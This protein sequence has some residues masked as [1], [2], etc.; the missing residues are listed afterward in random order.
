MYFNIVSVVSYKFLLI[1]NSSNTRV[2]WQFI[3]N[4]ATLLALGLN[5]NGSFHIPTA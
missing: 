2:D 5:L 1:Y 3:Y 4:N